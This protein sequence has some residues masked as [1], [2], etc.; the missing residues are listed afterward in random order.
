MKKIQLAVVLHV[1]DNPFLSYEELGDRAT[2]FLT[3]LERFREENVL[4]RMSLYFSGRFLEACLKHCP[5]QLASLRSWVKEGDLEFLAGGYAD[6]IFPLLPASSQKLQLQKLS[7]LLD[8]ALGARCRGAWMPSFVWENSLIPVLAENALEFVVLRDYQLEARLSRH[9]YRSGYWTVEDRGQLVRVVSSQ[10]E[11]AEAIRSG[12]PLQALKKIQSLPGDEPV[13]IDLP[14]FRTG[15]H[16]SDE[17]IPEYLE[18]FL[19]EARHHGVEFSF[20]PLSAAVDDQPSRGSITL[21]SS[22]GRNLGLPPDR[23]SCRDLLVIQPECNI[24]HKKM[25]YLHRQLDSVQDERE[26]TRLETLLLGAQG[27]FFYRNQRELGGVR[28][29][30]DRIQC[31]SSL[32]TADAEFRSS[33]GRKGIRLDVT[34]FLANGSKQLLLSTDVFLFL[35]EH[36]FGGRMRIFDYRP[37]SLAL[38]NGYRESQLQEKGGSEYDV[39]PVSAFVDFLLDEGDPSAELID[40]VLEAREGM[41]NSPLEYQLKKQNQKAQI[42]MAGE[43]E[44]EIRGKAQVMQVEKVYSVSPTAADFVV[45]WSLIN[46]TFQKFSGCFGSESGLCFGSWDTSAMKLKCNGKKVKLEADGFFTPEADSLQVSDDAA[47][48]QLEWTFP[49]T[50]GVRLVPV[51]SGDT[52]DGVAKGF[53]YFRLFFFWNCE[54]S[55]QEKASFMV[56]VHAKKKRRLLAGKQ[57]LF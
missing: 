2:H 54:L 10:S 28:Y 4:P 42:L 29:L 21:P 8:K 7:D 51:Y 5:S 55:G 38:V 34:D 41:L 27:I 12:K 36:R 19:R 39:E 22:V 47:G 48:V 14:L 40:E 25:L 16:R 53:Q 31:H 44:T 37:A 32:I 1:N 56:R 9:T 13:V 52:E 17:E 35:T 46:T 3:V 57:S 33:M 11:V 6:P 20:K 23:N 50:A 30:R 45:S 26:R 49:K 15:R 24:L 43:Q 18:V